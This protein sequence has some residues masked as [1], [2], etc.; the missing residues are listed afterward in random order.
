M[1]KTNYTELIKENS[2]WNTGTPSQ[3]ALK[4]PLYGLEAGHFYTKP[5]YFVERNYHDS[6]LLIYTVKG[7]GMVNKKELNAHQAIIIDCHSPHRYENMSSDWEFLWLHF[8][9]TAAEGLYQLICSEE[10]EPLNTETDFEIIL[11]ELID[12]FYVQNTVSLLKSSESIQRLIS[13]IA[14]SVANGNNSSIDTTLEYIHS[15]YMNQLSV[16][17]MAAMINLSKYHFIRIFKRTVGVTPYSYLTNYRITM[18]KRMLVETSL[19]ID[20]ISQKCGYLDTA[21]FISKFKT[22][23]GMSPHKYR[24]STGYKL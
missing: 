14:G 11:T 13:M 16:D 4:M 3:A 23:S 24:V 6:F 17:E 9:G 22:H 1:K 18:A 5:G 8:N 10:N 19:S 7:S 15:N 12:S 20:E 21:N 2:L